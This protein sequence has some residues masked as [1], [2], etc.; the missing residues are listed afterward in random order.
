MRYRQTLIVFKVLFITLILGLFYRQ[1]IQGEYFYNQSRRNVIRVISLE[2][3]RGRILDRNGVVL[4]DTIPS[5]DVSIIPQEVRNKPLLFER[6]SKILGMPFEEIRQI[7]QRRY[8]NP[9][10]PVIISE[11]LDKNEIIALEENK[12]QLPGVV[13][14]IRPLRFYP[15]GK[16]TSHVLGHLGQIDSYRIT[17]LK[18]YGYEMSDLVGYGGVEEY[19]DLVL[20][21]ENG[22]EQVEVDNRGQ[23][24]RTVGYKPPQSGQDIQITLDMRIQKIADDVMHGTRGAVVILDPYSGDV[25]ALSSYPSYDPNDFVK[26]NDSVIRSLLQDRRSPLFNRAIAGQYPPGS[27]FKIVTTTSA[28]EKDASLT[29]K[30]FVCNGSM[31]IGNRT[32]NCSSTHGAENLRDAVIHS[33]NVYFY[34]LGM[35]IG[36]DILHKYASVLGLSRRTGIDLNYEA[37]GFIPSVN[38]KKVIMFQSWSKGDTANMAIG[39]GEVLVTPLQLARMVS[40]FANGGELVHPHLIK[41]IGNKNFIGK[42]KSVT[43]KKDV[44]KNIDSYLYGVVNN[45]E[46]TAYTA[47]VEGLRIYG[48]TGTAQVHGKAAHG[49]LVGYVG[50]DKPKYAFCVFLENVGS[51]HVACTAAERI[52][53]E[54]SKQGLI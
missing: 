30:T 15:F 22:G 14:D 25:I 47:R 42:N 19:Y 10:V 3:A 49:W 23:R 18:P 11:K 44:L 40:V 5:F 36:P 53:E 33:C 32:Y 20:R 8:L 39:Q 45:P 12:L 9:F 1:V 2:A 6:L 51:S 17:K 46:G 13:V 54:M 43:I 48:K 7:Y 28:L 41:A 52:L 35:L 34:S 37:A 29:N 16:A 27:V 21:G 26:G 4:A 31:Q 24:V 38:W 50:R